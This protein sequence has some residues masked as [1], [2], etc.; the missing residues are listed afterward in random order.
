MAQPLWQI[1]LREKNRC[2]IEENNSAS[3]FL[4]KK[5]QEKIQASIAEALTTGYPYQTADI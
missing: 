1:H 2:T 4:L 3:K 5:I